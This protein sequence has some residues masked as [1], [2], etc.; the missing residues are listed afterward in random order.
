MD[1]ILRIHILR[2]I[3][4]AFRDYQLP[5]TVT[6]IDFKKA[7]DSISRK[8]IFS[9]LRHYGIPQPMV[10][11]IGVLYNNSK[12]AVMVD[13]NISETFNVTTGVLQGD[14]LAP[15]LFIVL[16]EYL[17]KKNTNSVVV[18]QGRRSSRYPSKS[19]KDLYFAD[20]GIVNTKSTGT[21]DSDSSCN[22]GSG[23]HHQCTQNCLHDIQLQPSILH[24]KFMANLSNMCPTLN[25]W[26]R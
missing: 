25:I 7:F 14:V 1:T 9:V 23:P 21:A 18:T 12:S 5:L 10:N 26:T 17:M 8:V 13:G 20:D 24:S 15:F 4:D 22:R 16:L 11:A 6:F 2:R 3:I 19:I